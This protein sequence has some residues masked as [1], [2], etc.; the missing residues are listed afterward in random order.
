MRAQYGAG[1]VSRSLVSWPTDRAQG[2]WGQVISQEQVGPSGGVGAGAAPTAASRCPAALSHLRPKPQPESHSRGPPTP[3]LG[4][5]LE[6]PGAGPRQQ[7][8]CRGHRCGGTEQRAGLGQTTPRGSE[9]RDGL[10]YTERGPL[11]SG[12]SR[13]GRGCWGQGVSWGCSRDASSWGTRKD[14]LPIHHLQGDRRGQDPIH[15]LPGAAGGARPPRPVGTS[16]RTHRGPQ[17]AFSSD[18][19]QRSRSREMTGQLF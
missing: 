5:P 14:R 6:V 17:R 15:H 3:G 16:R 11:R 10:S 4:G 18:S 19:G 9:A 8:P 13:A 12:E 7:G 1:G 2:A